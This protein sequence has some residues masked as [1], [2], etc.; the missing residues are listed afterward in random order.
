MLF[1]GIFSYSCCIPALGCSKR[2]SPKL[3]PPP[4]SLGWSG[5]RAG[6]PL[7]AFPGSLCG[8]AGKGRGKSSSRLPGDGFCSEQPDS[9]GV[10]EWVGARMLEPAGKAYLQLSNRVKGSQA[11][12]GT[13]ESS[14]VPIQGWLLLANLSCAMRSIQRQQPPPARCSFPSPCQARPCWRWEGLAAFQK[15]IGLEGFWSCW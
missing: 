5:D 11:K 6:H 12:A 3:L 10:W 15:I 2:F 9:A 7:G 4:T 8:A 14:Q 13:A 1:F